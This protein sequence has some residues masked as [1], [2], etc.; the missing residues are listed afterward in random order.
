M[1]GDGFWRGDKFKMS[2]QSSPKSSRTSFRKILLDIGATGIWQALGKLAQA[3]GLVHATNCLGV[4]NAGI[5]GSVMG[6]A[7]IF[8]V[9][10]S[11]GIDVV[12]VRHVS[13]RTQSLV[14]LVPVIFTTRLVLHVF[15]ASIW[16]VGTL[17]LPLNHAET[18]A[19]LIGGFYLLV[20]GMNYQWYFQATERMP[21]LSRLQTLTTFGVSAYFLIFFRPGKAAGME[22]LVLALA[23]G[24]VTIWVWFQVHREV[25]VKMLTKHFHKDLLSLLREGQANWIFGVAYNALTL[26]G[27]IL[28]PRLISENAD[29]QVGC[30]RSSNQLALA[31]QLI[32]TYISYIFYPKIITWRRRQIPHF[33]SRVFGLTFLMVAIGL[34]SF[35]IIAQIGEPFFK[36]A[37][38]NADF[39]PGFEV[40]PVMVL[41]KFIGMASGFLTWG[42]L[43]EHKDWL[44]ARCCVVPVI[45]TAILHFWFVPK[46]GFVAAG[47]LYLFGE[48]LLFLA[49][50][51]AFLRLKLPVSKAK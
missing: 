13:A 46:H 10:L 32:L 26:F 5:S 23:H 15:V 27:L 9:F 4:E 35:G 3:F 43:A 11:L 8:Q 41:G 47:W 51:L 21:L 37:Y 29:A 12:A 18:I 36:L 28:I 45:I 30:F 7:M 50:A 6:T 25:G 40:L 42:L 38:S 20:I 19:W 17:L 2:A 44:A 39:H 16:F 49:C 33:R 48:T 31:L 1:D 22:L 34:V 14:Q 24:S